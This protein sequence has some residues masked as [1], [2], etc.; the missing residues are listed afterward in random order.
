MG[1]GICLLFAGEMGFHA[2]GLG[3]MSK[4]TEHKLKW[5]WD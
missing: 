4:K 1:I 2:L 5:E 3:F